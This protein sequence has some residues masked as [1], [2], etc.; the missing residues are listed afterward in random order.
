MSGIATYG[1]TTTS[2]SGRT[3]K[4]R[5]EG[6]A[7]AGSFGECSEADICPKDTTEGDRRGG[8]RTCRPPVERAVSPF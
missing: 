7:A 6:A 3:A 2:R 4:R 8:N 5:G 1:N